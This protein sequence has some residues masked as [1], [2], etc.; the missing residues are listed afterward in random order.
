MTRRCCPWGD[1]GEEHAR[2]GDRTATPKGS[3][4]GISLVGV[5]YRRWARVWLESDG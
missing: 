2:R 5:K 1:L 3:R 4:A